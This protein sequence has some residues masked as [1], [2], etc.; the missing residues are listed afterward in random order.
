MNSFELGLLLASPLLIALV[1]AVVL[2]VRGYRQ[3]EVR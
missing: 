3:E 2:Y 1:T